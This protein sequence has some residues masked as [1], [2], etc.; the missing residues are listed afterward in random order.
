MYIACQNLTNSSDTDN[1]IGTK[2]VKTSIQVASFVSQIINS[3]VFPN[4]ISSYK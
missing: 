3:S 1:E 2:L 4:Y